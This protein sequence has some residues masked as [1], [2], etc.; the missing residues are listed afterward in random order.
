MEDVE[1]IIRPEEFI[2]NTWM[3]H[4]FVSNGLIN[5]GIK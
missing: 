4:P 5:N 1:F 3:S 2:R